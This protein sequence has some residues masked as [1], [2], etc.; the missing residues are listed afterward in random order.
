MSQQPPLNMS[1][2]TLPTEIISRICRFFGLLL[3]YDIVMYDN[4]SFQSLRLTCRSLYI[5]TMFDAEMR[6][7]KRLSSLCVVPDYDGL[8]RFLHFSKIWAFRE[9]IKNVSIYRPRCWPFNG[10]WVHGRKDEEAA[11]VLWSSET[12]LLL[13]VCFSNLEGAP[14]L[15]E[16][17]CPNDCVIQ[18]LQALSYVSF[19]RKILRVS[20]RMRTILDTEIRALARYDPDLRFIQ[21]IELDVRKSSHWFVVDKL[22]TLATTHKLNKLLSNLSTVEHFRLAGCCS[23]IC[24]HYDDMIQH[25]TDTEH[26]NIVSLE[27]D[28]V[29]ID[30]DRLL[31]FIEKHAQTLTTL[32][33][34]DVSVTNGSWF[35]IAQSLLNLPNLQTFSGFGHLFQKEPSRFIQETNNIAQHRS[36]RNFAFDG[37][38]SIRLFLKALVMHSRTHGYHYYNGG[39]LVVALPKDHFP[40]TR[41]R[42]SGSNPELEYARDVLSPSEYTSCLKR[43][44]D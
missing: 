15:K 30:G 4:R 40:R 43:L 10:R 5:K 28:D 21:I 14:Q 39:Y 9:H 41:R 20:I 32:R 38:T 26:I 7:K 24:C 27:L 17:S 33:L 12:I 23:L 44:W 11:E 19:T 13:A 16:I 29:I 6:Y 25:L 2:A 34:S 3:K 18:V 22:K 36:L 42:Y 37:T 8:C 31:R 1:L 35:S